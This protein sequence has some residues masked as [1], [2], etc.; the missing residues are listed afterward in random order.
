MK[1]CLA[2]WVLLAPCVFAADAGETLFR[3]HCAPCHGAKGDGGRGANL[4]VRKLPRAPDDAT[5]GAIIA[6]GI[7]GTEMP[8]TRMIDTERMELIAYVRGLAQ[9]QAAQAAGDRARGEQLFWGKGNCGQC[10]TVGPRGGRVGPDLSNIGERRGPANL[11]QS[12]LDPEAET[13]EN[14]AQYR[15]VIY[16]P[17]NYLRVR[18]VTSDGKQIAG[19]RVDEDT[20]TIQIRD[21]AS[22]IYSFRKDQLQELHEDWGKSPMPSYRGVFSEA[23]LGDVIAYLSSLTGAP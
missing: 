22:N 4:A 14:F 15:K 11:R 21:D 2:A 9:T 23:E 18:V 1:T 12:V 8:A 20:F 6:Q 13:P 5:L 10:H 19:A 7:P 3:Q 17:D 16:M